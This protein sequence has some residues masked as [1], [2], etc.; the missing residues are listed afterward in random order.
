MS[1]VEQQHFSLEESDG[2]ATLRI[3]R[4]DARVNALNAELMRELH[5]VLS[6]LSRRESIRFLFITSN[7][8][9]VFVAGADIHEIERL[10][11]SADAERKSENGQEIMN[12]LDDLPFPTMA[13][14]DG[15]CLGGGCELAL[16]CD[17]R[18]ASCDNPKT[19]I[20]LPETQLGILPAWG[21]T[22]RMPRLVG[23]MQAVQMI[24]SGKSVDAEKAARAKLIDFAYPRAFLYEWARELAAAILDG[25]AGGE[26]AKRRKSKKLGTRIIENNS[27]G[28]AVLCARA[29]RDT[30]KKTDGHY[31]APLE[32]LRVVRRAYRK[33]RAVALAVERS[34]FARLAST[35]VARNLVRL[36]FAREAVKNHHA[37]Q[38]EGEP[39][40]VERAAVLGAGV[41]GGRIGWLF[42]Y[43]D[44]PVVMKDIDWEAVR[45][46]Y[47]SAREA[48]EQLERARKLGSRESRLKLHKIHGAVDYRSLGTPDFVVE[49]VVEN[50][51]VKKRVLTEIEERID[52]N[53]IIASNTS[54]LSITEMA[55]ALK[56]PGR[57]IGMHFFNP[58]NRMP[59]VEVIAGDE[60][61]EET[62]RATGV[63]A[64]ELG[65]TPVVVRNCTGFLVNR[66]L[67]PYLNEAVIMLD[68]GESFPEIDRR[69]K[70]FGM[71]MGPF[72][73]LDEV[74]IDVGYAVARECVRAYGDRMQTSRFFETIRAEDDLHGKKSGAG[75]YKYGESSGRSRS[76]HA[77]K[78][79]RRMKTLVRRSARS[80]GNRLSEFDSLHRP[81]LAMV[82]EAARAL[83]ER[84]VETPTEVDIAMIMGTGFPPFRGGL[85]RYADDLGVGAVRDTLSSYAERFG[86]RFRPA[87]LIQQLAGE[88]RRFYDISGE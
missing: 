4:K 2:F 57:F 72:R 71:P 79:N 74:G 23:L 6:D 29:A 46:G 63:L 14:I 68:D 37:L 52:D 3:D 50:L 56:R 26:I 78:P 40:R 38:G 73:L 53:A 35:G 15:A 81:L 62:V 80:R 13:I 55:K 47:A 67:M 33:R 30:R 82:N 1:T 85:L 45:N 76:R 86:E 58:V 32:A 75:F 17:Y 43:R 49:A 83:E 54:A 88:N 65:K 27:L 70:A 19:Q 69:I 9:N 8:P 87:D 5:A 12:L 39:K 51:D 21:G 77:P 25:S 48:Y 41:M 10:E 7:K 22:W 64:Q 31:P 34:A 24:L 20:G 36:Y 84:I 44:I 11:D 16:A 42:S 66:L 59:L 18:V 60:T 28:R 61:N